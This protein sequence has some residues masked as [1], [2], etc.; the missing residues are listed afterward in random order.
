MVLSDVKAV[1]DTAAEIHS[2]A[3]KKKLE[4]QRRALWKLLSD[5]KP[6]QRISAAGLFE[7][8]KGQVDAPQFA[9]EEE[10]EDVLRSMPEVEFV[11]S[12]K[13]WKIAQARPNVARFGGSE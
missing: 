10:V 3:K 13:T 2:K 12:S 8:F 4:G 5:L 11:L 1:V 6:N 9:D 7:Y